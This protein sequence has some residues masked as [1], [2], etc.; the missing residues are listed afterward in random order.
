MRNRI[1]R[2]F[3]RTRL[4]AAAIGCALAL[5]ACDHLLRVQDPDVA[6]PGSLSGPDKLSTQVSSALGDFQVGYNGDGNG[7]EGIV[8]MTGLLT[9]EFSFTETFPTRIVIDERSMTPDNVTL[10]TI[11]FNIQRARASALRASGAF[12]TVPDS[13]GSPGHSEVLSL[14]GYAQTL[15]AEMYCGDVPFSTLNADGTLANGTPLSTDQMLQAAVA[16]FDS[17]ILIA[18]AAGSTKFE[19]LAR[20][21]KARALVDMG[22]AGLQE[23]DTVAGPVGGSFLFQILH[24]ANSGRENNGVN[25]LIWQEGRWSIGET[26][27]T[28][29]LPFV[30]ANDPRV[31]NTFLGRGFATNTQVWGPNADSSRASPIT[32]SSGVEA[33]LIN[34]E[35][36]LGR[37][38]AVAWLADLNALRAASGLGLTPLVDPV[39]TTGRQNLMF[40][41]RAFWLY[42]TSHRLG[43]LRRLI[44]Q[45]A[46]NSETVFPTGTY[47]YRGIPHG[48]YGPDVNFPIPVEEGNNPAFVGSVCDVT[49]P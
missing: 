18:Q 8:N 2:L 27:G 14:E 4:G 41:E 39:T 15:M 28:N 11:Y 47:I 34:A 5:A 6:D 35:A 38:D 44:R 10:T 12:N 3:A 31:T 29:G 22:G 16:N 7:D 23:A 48:T 13:G 40:S 49:Q 26:E 30:S 42:G 21:G 25:E 20:V 1:S 46:R 9:D 19:D 45:Y 24:S 37:S 32:L 33:R 36:A 17:A 43:D